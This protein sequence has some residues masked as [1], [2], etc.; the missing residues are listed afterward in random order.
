MSHLERE[1]LAKQENYRFGTLGFG[2][3]H[4]RF[5]RPN[6]GIGGWEAKNLGL[7]CAQKVV[8]VLH[9]VKDLK[10]YLLSCAELKIM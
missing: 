8:V 10:R 4:D 7:P 2:R 5:W 1:S 3:R 6:L 9:K